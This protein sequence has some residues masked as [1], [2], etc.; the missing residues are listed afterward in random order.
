MTMQ[1]FTLPQGQAAALVPGVQFSVPGLFQFTPLLYACLDQVKAKFDYAIPVR[2]CYGAPQVLWNCGRLMIKDPHY[3]R[4]ETEKELAGAVRRGI[5]PLLTFSSVQVTEEELGDPR[6]NELL[7]MLN[8]CRGG[9]IVSDERL[10]DYI[11]AHYPQVELHASVILTAFTERRDAAYYEGLAEHYARYVVHPDDN[12]DRDLLAKLPKDRGEIILNERCVYQCAQ[13]R[14]HYESIT[15]DQ[16]ELLAGGCRLS[17][18]LDRCPFVPDHKQGTTHQGNISLTT[19]QAADIAGLG[20]SLFKLQGRLD[21]PYVFFFD[22]LRYALENDRAFPTVY[23]IFAYT[24]RSYLK[25]KAH[26]RKG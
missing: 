11:A 10:R 22:F 5:T 4:Q 14:E 21:N 3:S 17:G 15:R 25:E 20:F 16:R 9:A 18:F 26:K 19:R 8:A 6:G 7:A 12:F 24:I 1:D 2:Y 13:R 23:P